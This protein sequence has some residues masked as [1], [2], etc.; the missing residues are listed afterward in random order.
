[1]LLESSVADRTSSSAIAETALQG[2]SVL[3]KNRRL[4]SVDVIGLSSTTVT[5]SDSKA[6]EFGKITQN[7]G[8][9]AV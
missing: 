1:V 7:K 9:Y 6:I 8:Y 5:Q 3:A 4:Y 2:G